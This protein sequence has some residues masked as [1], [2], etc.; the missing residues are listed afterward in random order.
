LA[1]LL[2]G[3][4]FQNKIPKFFVAFGIVFL[5]MLIKVN[6]PKILAGFVF[7]LVIFMASCCGNDKKRG[8]WSGIGI[9]FFYA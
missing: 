5:F 9:K 7:G 1:L 8:E 4:R 2:R 3:N 6:I